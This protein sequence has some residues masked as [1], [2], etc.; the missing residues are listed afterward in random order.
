MK[1]YKIQFTLQADKDI[2]V[3]LNY[4]S[5]FCNAP[6][7]AKRYTE[8]I[9]AEIKLLTKSA[10]SIQISNQLSVLKYRRSARRINCK[11]HTIVY[12]VH[13]RVVIIRA[14]LSGALFKH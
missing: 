9:L 14:V 7:T 11:K 10:E 13:G 8:G 2:D 3:L 12:T 1:T 6:L 4:I 5:D